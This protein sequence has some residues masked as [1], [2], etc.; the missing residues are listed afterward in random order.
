MLSMAAGQTAVN[1]TNAE[2]YGWG[3]GC[4]GWYLVK[5][6]Q[7]TIIQERMPPGTAETLHVH[8][9][10]RQFFYIL[11]G[12]AVMEHGSA[13][14]KLTAGDGLEI[15]PG[16]PHRIF[17]PGRRDLEILVTSQPPSHAD[18]LEVAPPK[19]PQANK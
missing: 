5:D 18:R 17:N 12:E 14:T 7:L 1:R 8:A 11:S 4:D 3:Q 13:A 19:A 10:S 15:P 6:L 2:H 9:K 16:V